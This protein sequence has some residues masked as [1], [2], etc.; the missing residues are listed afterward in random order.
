MVGRGSGGGL[1]ARVCRPWT[2]LVLRM[3]FGSVGLV[4]MLGLALT[5]GGGAGTTLGS[6]APSTLCSD[7]F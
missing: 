4:E 6:G 2:S 7:L 5:L 3:M 1:F